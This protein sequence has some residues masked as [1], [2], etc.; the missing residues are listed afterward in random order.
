MAQLIVTV[1]AAF[2]ARIGEVGGAHASIEYAQGCDIESD[3]TSGIAA[4]VAAANRSDAVVVVLGDSAGTCDEAADRMELDLMG[5][6]ID[7]L[8]A[9]LQLG[10]P[11]VCVLMALM[12]VAAWPISKVPM[13]AISLR[14]S[15]EDEHKRG[16]MGVPRSSTTVSARRRG[17]CTLAQRPGSIGSE[18]C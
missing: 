9:L 7:L 10:K 17:S 11:V 5:R 8:Q 12:S 18:T 4:A 13:H 1:R 14:H 16:D 2:E 3:D 15:R 6:Q